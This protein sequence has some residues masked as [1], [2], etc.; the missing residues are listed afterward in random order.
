VG[1]RRPERVAGGLHAAA[2]ALRVCRIENDASWLRKAAAYRFAHS[3][4]IAVISSRKA[5]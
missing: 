1:E 5:D 4:R 2:L 3:T